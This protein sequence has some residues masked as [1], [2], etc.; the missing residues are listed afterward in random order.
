MQEMA[1]LDTVET[2]CSDVL[3]SHSLIL[4]MYKVKELSQVALVQDVIEFNAEQFNIS[5]LIN[6]SASYTSIIRDKT[7]LEQVLG[8]IAISRLY[9]TN[10]VEV[11]DWTN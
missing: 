3:V 1:Y 2:H 9:I 5:M 10:E 8:Y 7:I 6:N 11:T 4:S